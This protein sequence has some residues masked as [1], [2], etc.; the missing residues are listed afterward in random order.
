M[1]AAFDDP[2]MI[3]HD[4][5]VG[6]GDG[7][8]SMGD[9]QH[10][11]VPGQPVKRLLHKVFRFRIGK[12]G[13]LVEDE[14]RSVAEDG[15]GNGEPL[16]LPA[17]KTTVGS[18]HGIV[19]VRQPKHPVVDLRFAGR[20]LDLFGGGIRYRQRDVFGGGAMHKLGFL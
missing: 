12:R 15:T 5:L 13:G 1:G 18:E 11:A 9:Y 6:P 20:D 8:Q 16:S 3:E 14:D 19:A 7:M 2:T 4:D 10:G 17:R